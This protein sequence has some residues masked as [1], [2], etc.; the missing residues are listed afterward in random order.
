MTATRLYIDYAADAGETGRLSEAAGLVIDADLLAP[1]GVEDLDAP[2]AVVRTKTPEKHTGWHEREGLIW[3]S[4]QD[5]EVIARLRD[6]WPGLHWLPRLNLYQPEISYRF[7]TESLGEGFKFYIP[8]TAAIQAYRT[9]LTEQ[10]LAGQLSRAAALGFDALWLHASHAE[11]AGQ[12]LDL[13]LLEQ[14][15]AGFSGKIW[16]SGGAT[17]EQHLLNLSRQGGAAAVVVSQACAIQCGC[18]R[19]QLALASGEETGVPIKF[20]SQQT[21]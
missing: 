16:L 21:A 4:D 15:A 13:D 7:N 10:P 17:H 20:A 5:L 2:L 9:L 6:Q 14:A 18:D 1:D 3:S 12:G 19:L 8:D 11:T